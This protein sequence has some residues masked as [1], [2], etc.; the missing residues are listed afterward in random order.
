MH[1]IHSGRPSTSL[2]CCPHATG[3]RMLYTGPDYMR[4]YRTKRPDFTR[5]IGERMP[6]AESTGDVDYLCRAAPSTPAP[7][8]KDYYVGG[9]GWGVS[10][11]S[12]LNR[13]Q[14]CSNHQIKIGEFRRNCEDKITHRYQNPWQ[15]LPRILDSQGS[16]SRSALA[17]TQDRDIDYCN[18]ESEW[19]P[20]IE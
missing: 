18:P 17:W 7:L 2:S 1:P 8:P 9:I 12:F 13:S 10:D 6:S 16:G 3:K 11:F 4:D 20:M 5:Y 19:A 15:P 14:L